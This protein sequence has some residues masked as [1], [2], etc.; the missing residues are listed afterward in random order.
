MTLPSN[1]I[2][3]V[4]DSSSSYTYPFTLA[5][6]R[7]DQNFSQVVGVGSNVSF[8]VSN[9]LMALASGTRAPSV[10]FPIYHQS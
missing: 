5:L 10:Q 7:A 3:I 4:L 8:P 2:R 9:P 6:S 1:P